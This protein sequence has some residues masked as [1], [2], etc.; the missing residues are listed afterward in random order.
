[1]NSAGLLL[2]STAISYQH[3]LRSGHRD[4]S[5]SGL[6][7]RQTEETGSGRAALDLLHF[8]EPDRKDRIKA[9]FREEG[10]ISAA[11][12]LID[13]IIQSKKLR[14]G[15]VERADHRAGDRRVQTRREVRVEQP[16]GAHSGDRERQLR[17]A[18]R[19]PAADAGQHEDRG[20]VRAL[21]A[22]WG[23]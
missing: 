15:M 2:I 4:A 5:H 6:F 8:L 12:L 1:M 22:G 11:A 18:D 10:N 20:R 7:Q 3:E 17:P 19:P 13:E 23:S 21:P 14:T 9:K 16:T